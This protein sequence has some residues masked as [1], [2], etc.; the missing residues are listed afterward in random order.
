MMTVPARDD[1]HGFLCARAILFEREQNGLDRIRV[2]ALMLFG[3][4][5]GEINEEDI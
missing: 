4:L 5:G 2:Q 1:A 3:A